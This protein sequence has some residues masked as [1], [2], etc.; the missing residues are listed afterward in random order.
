M[1][2]LVSGDEKISKAIKYLTQST[3]SHAAI[4][5]GD[6]LDKAE[7]DGEPHRLIEVNLGEGC[8]TRALVQVCPEHIRA[9][10]GQFR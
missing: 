7:P 2:L 4:Y 10:V 8:V 3:W 6:I 1:L 9:F 5:V